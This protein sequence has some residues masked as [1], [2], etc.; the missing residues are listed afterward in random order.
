[1]NVA[2]WVNNYIGIPYKF[3]GYGMD[4]ADC[5]GLVRMILRREYGKE[6][7]AYAHDDPSQHRIAAIVDSVLPTAPVEKVTDPEPGDLV[8]LTITGYPCHIGVVAGAGLM[9]HTLFKH[10]SALESYAG[11]RWAKRLEG[12]YR[13][14]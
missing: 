9:V 13:V 14:R 8:L 3:A 12:F 7:P 10:D 11:S 1:M 5:W 6:L 2:P 4:G